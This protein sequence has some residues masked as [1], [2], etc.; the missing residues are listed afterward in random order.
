MEIEKVLKKTGYTSI[1]TSIILGILGFIMFIYSKTTLKI[2]TYAI[3][4]MLIFLGI[5]KVIGYLRDKNRKEYFNY[6]LIYGIVNAII[7]LVLITHPGI[8][9]GLLGIT[10]GIWIIYTG[11][12]RLGLSLRLKEYKTK[13]WIPMLIISIA[14]L[15]MGIYIIIAPDLIIATL[16]SIILMYSIMDLI[17]GITFLINVKRFEKMG[18]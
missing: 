2:I 15:A 11:L 17:E 16:G 3:A 18:E 12:T 10:I 13:T 8:L 14:I 9:E 4:G 5:I 7:G 1:I 6:D